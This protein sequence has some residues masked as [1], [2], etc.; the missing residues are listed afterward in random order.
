[1]SYNGNIAYLEKVKFYFYNG[2]IYSMFTDIL[3][4]EDVQR[5]VKILK[6]LIEDMHKLKDLES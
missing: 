3:S 6:S 4:E 1:M 2:L 5:T